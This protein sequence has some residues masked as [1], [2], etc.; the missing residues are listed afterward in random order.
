MSRT[1]STNSGSRESLKL[2]A[3]CGWSAKAR[4][5][6]TTA[7][8]LRPVAAARPRVLQCVAFGGA[9]SRVVTTARSTCSSV[10]RRGAPGR[11]SSSSPSG[12]CSANRLRQVATVGR[13]TPS[14]WA[15]PL[16]VAPGAAQASTMRARMAS[17]CAVLRR[18]VQPSSVARSPVA[19]AI[20]TACGLGI[21]ASGP[22]GPQPPPAPC[23]RP[24]QAGKKSSTH[25]ARTRRP[26]RASPAS[27]SRRRRCSIRCPRGRRPPRRPCARGRGDRI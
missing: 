25:A 22:I 23:S 26:F 2:S 15:T 13:L 16:L 6:R 11:G 14:A 19:R 4:Q 18:R 10:I 20:G 3:R 5:I 24:S 7:V 17:A 1:L 8:W 12:P 27:P 9:A 21:G